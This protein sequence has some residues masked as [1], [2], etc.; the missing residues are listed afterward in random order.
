MDEFSGNGLGFTADGSCYYVVDTKASNVCLATLDP[1][2]TAFEDRLRIASSEFVGH[3]ILG[4]F[5]RDGK[6]LAYRAGVR[7]KIGPGDCK[8][9]INTLD[10]GHE[11]V[12]KPTPAFSPN[13]PMWDGPWVHP[14]GRSLLALGTGLEA[15][16][17]LYRVD[18]ATG[19]VTPIHAPCSQM[20]KSAAYS[21]DGGSTYL[22]TPYRMSK[23]DLASKR[24]RTLYEGPGA[25]YEFDVSA[26]GQWL[27]FYMESGV[28]AVMPSDGGEPRQVMHFDDGERTSPL[29]FVRWMPDGKHLLFKKRT[30]ELW[31]VNVE[32]GEQRQIAVIDIEL[33]DVSIHPDGRSIALTTYDAGSQLWVMEN[34]LPEQ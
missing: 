34:F 12:L 29:T 19:V 31:K 15:G 7:H 13:T 8:F 5:S 11:R 4:D 16:Y 30:S 2:A 27:A 21:P 6:F 10:T 26:D 23:L 18:V 33:M 14:D 25:R 9:V 1:T 3:T 17:G 32:T 22:R 28:L 24:E 20:V